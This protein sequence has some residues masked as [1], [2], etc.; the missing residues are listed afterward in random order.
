M[1]RK[2]WNGWKG[3]ENGRSR[4]LV[5]RGLG[6]RGLREDMILGSLGR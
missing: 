3:L 4:L 1:S 2:C 5:V 6:Y